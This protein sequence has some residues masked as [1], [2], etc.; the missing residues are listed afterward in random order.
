VGRERGRSIPF[1][2]VAACLEVRDQKITAAQDVQYRQRV[3]G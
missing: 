2:E 1:C 3:V